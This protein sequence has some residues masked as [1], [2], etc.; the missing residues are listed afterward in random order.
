MKRPRRLAS[1]L[2]ILIASMLLLLGA[3]VAPAGA[4]VV[5]GDFEAGSLAGWQQASTSQNS[6]EWL[7]TSGGKAPL[8]SNE[9][10]DLDSEIAA[11]EQ[12]IVE[13]EEGLEG[14][15]TVEEQEELEAELEETLDELE[16]AKQAKALGLGTLLP[17]AGGSFYAAADE[18]SPSSMIL[19][20]DV[21]LSADAEQT[22]SLD[23]YFHSFAPLAS[24]PP[25]P[26]TTTVPTTSR[27][28]ST[29]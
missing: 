3:A 5:N 1:R 12:Q 26:S 11:L 17:P 20:Q 28:A 6:G 24:P 16:E 7:I 22:L 27:C 2:A 25:T 10:A 8:S 9:G 14:V 23:F 4:D 15:V 21:A 29:C 13:L 18:S 19:Y